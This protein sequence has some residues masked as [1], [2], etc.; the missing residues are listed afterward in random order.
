MDRWI[1]DNI[2]SSVQRTRN[3]SEVKDLQEALVKRNSNSI[4]ALI[5]ANAMSD[6]VQVERK[7][8][9]DEASVCVGGWWGGGMA[10]S[11]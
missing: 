9:A 11:M 4:A 10:C 1:Y 7:K 2:C 8:Q 6:S 3:H 5:R